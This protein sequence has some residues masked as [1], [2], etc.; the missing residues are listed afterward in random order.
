[1]KAPVQAVFDLVPLPLKRLDKP[2][3][4]HRNGR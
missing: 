1:M 2:I 4:M 3:R